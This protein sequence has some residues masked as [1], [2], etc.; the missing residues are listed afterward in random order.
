MLAFSQ[1]TLDLGCQDQGTNR[2]QMP[3]MRQGMRRRN[4]VITKK[5][6]GSANLDVV[7]SEN[8]KGIVEMNLIDLGIEELVLY[9][10]SVIQK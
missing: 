8:V 4:R 7:K 5:D 2:P 6:I 1:F 9:P 10:I 3:W